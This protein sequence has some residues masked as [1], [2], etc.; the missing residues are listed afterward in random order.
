MGILTEE[1]CYGGLDNCL[2]L[3]IAPYPLDESDP[4]SPLIYTY[5]DINFPKMIQTECIA[6][7]P[8][9]PYDLFCTLVIGQFNAIPVLNLLGHWDY[10][11][12]RYDRNT[13]ETF[14]PKICDCP[15]TNE[16]FVQC[17]D[18]NFLFGL[19]IYDTGPTTPENELEKR[20]EYSYNPTI[21]LGMK[22]KNDMSALSKDWMTTAVLG[23]HWKHGRR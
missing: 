9:N 18:F 11:T 17:N 12:Y 4:N 8:N 6:F 2:E 16:S 20:I 10:D 1:T 19:I 3:L 21:R 7:D 5:I 23:L 14:R 15:L 22:Y 13:T